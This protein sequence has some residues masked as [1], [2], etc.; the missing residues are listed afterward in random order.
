MPHA[1]CADS[2]HG[3]CTVRFLPHDVSDL[4]FLLDLLSSRSD[5][6]S[7]SSV[8]DADQTGPLSTSWELRYCLLLWLSVCI[9]LPFSFRLLEPGAEDKIRHVGLRWLRT[10]GKES[11]AAAQVV[12]RYFSRDDVDIVPLLA[13]CETTLSSPEDDFI[14]SPVSS[15]RLC[16]EQYGSFTL[17][18]P[19]SYRCSAHSVSSWPARGRI[20][21]IQSCRACTASLRCCRKRTIQRRARLSRSCVARSRA[22]S[23]SLT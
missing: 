13:L 19:S 16:G 9:R 8:S 20:N 6:P 12:G 23:R 3:I 2:Q 1:H 11:D 22:G 14:V 4:S 10:S 5:L 7:T 18:I 21:S 15:A 17:F